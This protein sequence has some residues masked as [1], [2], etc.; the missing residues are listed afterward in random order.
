MREDPFVYFRFLNSAWAAAVCDAFYA[1]LPALPTAILHGDAHLEQYALTASARGLDDFDDAAHGPAAIDL[2]RFLG[3]IDLVSRRRGWTGDRNRLFDQFFDG[4]TRALS[5]PAFMPP[6]PAVVKRLRGRAVPTRV[7][8]LAWGESLMAPL[9]A[10]EEA[11]ATHSLALFANLM[12]ELHP[13][14][15]SDY[16]RPKRLGRLQM[17]VGSALARK[18][19]V[20]IEGPSLAPDD[21]LLLEAKELGRLDEVPC[22]QVPVSGEAFR[23]IAATEQIGR[24]R[25]GILAI[26]PRREGQGP[27]V[28]DWWMRDWDES[29][30]EVTLADFRSADELA[31]VARDAG[32]QFGSTNMRAASPA[33]EAQLRH[34]EL[35]AVKRLGP[36]LRATAV[37][38]VDELLASWDDW[39]SSAPGDR[40]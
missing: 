25:H 32:A 22:L 6:D 31:E 24:I 23:V 35:A 15:D 17:G 40:P 13:Q 26:V 20:R 10:A 33:L 27:E 16:F 5:D 21:D 36:R 19:L 28:R 18:I 9:T 34:A 38:L 4:Y 11:R 30:A 39:R 14:F 1:D 29:Y 7:A 2:V 12:Q 8:F 3:S 37:R